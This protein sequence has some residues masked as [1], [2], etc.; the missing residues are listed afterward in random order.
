MK[1]KTSIL[2]I[3]LAFIQFALAQV[4]IKGIVKETKNKS[5]LQSVSVWINHLRK[6]TLTNSDGVF[7]FINIPKGKITLQFSYIGYQRKD[8]LIDITSSSDI[9]LNIE[10]N[11]A[12]KELDEVVIVSSSRTNSRIEDLPTKVEV[13][14]TEEV[15]EENQIKPGNLTGL[16][17]DFAGIQVQQ[18][19]VA[20]GNADMRIQGLPGKYTQLL[21]D[22]MPLFEGYSGSFSI[23][24]LPPLDLQ[25]IELIKGASSTLYGGGAIAGMVNLVSKKPKLGVSEKSFTVN[26]STL[27]ENNLNTFLSARNKSTGYTFFAGG[28]LQKAADVNNDGF[29]DVPNVKSVF[30][31]P[32]FFIYASPK[33]TWILGYT[34]SYEDREGGDM[35]VLNHQTDV[36]HQFFIQNKSLHQIADIT[37]E[38]KM[39]NNILLT[40]KASASFLNRDVITNVFGMKAGQANWYSEVALSQKSSHHNWVAGINFNGEDF[41]KKLPD[42]SLIP[43][44]TS[45]TIGLFVQDD[46]NFAR[47]FTLQAGLRFDHHSLYGNFILPRLSLMYKMNQ[48]ITMRLGGGLGYKTPTL[49]SAEIDERDYHYL[50]GYKTG[51]QAEKSYGINYDINCKTKVDEWNITFN[52]TFFYTRIRQP[53][54]LDSVSNSASFSY[55]NATQPLQ[56]LGFETYVQ[57]KLD[58]LEIYFGYVY[59]NA[60]R[61]YETAHPNLPLI[62]GNKLATL[63]SF[64]VSD[65]FRAGLELSYT[66]KQYLEDGGATSPY[67]IGAAMIKYVLKKVSLV[68]NCENL[69]D[70]RQSKNNAV[71]YP[72]YNNPK[73]PEIWAPLDGRALNLSM[74]IKF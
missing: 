47:A 9:Q 36:S 55:Y 56:T 11:E 34:L 69:F 2:L 49:F 45:N 24:Q 12:G 70:Y 37:L 43:N 32:R 59:T 68:L 65:N 63:V 73:F 61:K 42:S 38:Q 74:Q 8:T 33:S 15:G 19:N 5:A 31:H 17:G 25:Q 40:A 54:L 57:A 62:A 30:V 60:R 20:T 10:L 27:Q 39:N 13:V 58:E 29:S 72:P 22:G 41:K 64:E 71:V 44:E 66:D 7:S 14:G 52:Q 18:T 35:N 4:T 46:W 21:R 23:L 16:L 3:C 28:T 6:G 26:R 67:V 53:L 51:I 1:L 50:S 48:G